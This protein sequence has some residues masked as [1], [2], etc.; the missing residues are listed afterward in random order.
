MAETDD[1]VAFLE[2]FFSA[3]QSLKGKKALVTAGPTYEAIDP[4]RFIGNGS[5]GQMGYA[6]VQQALERGAHVTLI[7]G[8]VKLEPPYGCD[9]VGVRTTREMQ[10]AVDRALE[11]APAA[12]VLIMAAAVAD[13]RPLHASDHKIK[14]ESSNRAPTIELE[15][16]PDILLGLKDR[17]GLEKLLR[18]GFAA[19]TDDLLL[20]AE[21]K[22]NNKNLDL[23]V[24]N[25]AVSSIG[26]PDNEVTLIE[27]GGLALHLER[28]PKPRVAAAILDKIVEILAKKLSDTEQE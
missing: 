14:K 19:E 5:S 27:R 6:L 13:F 10:A 9:F 20:N 25:E 3:Q 16:N 4:V 21:K 22:L 17:A 18:V 12:D 24:A 11:T 15:L 26:H 8:P 7:S 2:T 23:I 28:M 1:I